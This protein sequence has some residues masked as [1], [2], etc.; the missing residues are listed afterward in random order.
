[1]RYQFQIEDFAMI[2]AKEAKE[3]LYDMFSQ[4]FITTAVSKSWFQ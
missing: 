3:L 1:M 2:S 4:N